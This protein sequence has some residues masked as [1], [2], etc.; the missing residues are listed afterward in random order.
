MEPLT[1][2]SPRPA[3]DSASISEWGDEDV[4]VGLR[5]NAIEGHVPLSDFHGGLRTLFHDWFPYGAFLAADWV[6]AQGTHYPG[7]SGRYGYPV[8]LPRALST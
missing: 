1:F 8:A 7:L 2:T 5:I 4:E 6:R 3:I